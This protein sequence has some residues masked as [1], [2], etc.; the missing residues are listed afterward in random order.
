MKGI[1]TAVVLVILAFGS[2]ITFPAYIPWM[3]LIW[4]ALSLIAIARNRPMWPWLATCVLI[5][6]MKRPGY[7]AGLAGFAL[8]VIAVAIIDWRMLR[9]KPES[10]D[11]RRVAIFAFALAIAT[12]F[13]G[14]SRWYAANTSKLL[15][16]NQ[17]PI[18]CLGDSLTDFGYPQ[19]LERLVRVPIAD[20]G[21]NGITTDDGIDM[22]PDILAVN[23]QLVVIELGGHDYNADK[24]TREATRSN[25]VQLIDAFRDRE[26]AV[27]LVEIPRGFI[28]DPYDGLERE[29]CA[30]YDLQLIDDSI[31]RSFV[32]NSPILPPGIWLDPSNRYS[33]DGL[34]PN[35]LGNRRFARVVA[36]SLESVFGDSILR[37]ES[38]AAQ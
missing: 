25:L 23:P 14:A 2:L 31:I 26:I 33:N 3:A 37:A 17:R 32:F 8:V 35:A 38:V 24:K 13:Y 15:V 20:F 21:V 34:H 28:S 27:I 9:N 11:F 29:L 22:I 30:K 19:E 5:I 18:A 16:A 7:T 1:L 10:M 12:I 4:I 36:E 6:L